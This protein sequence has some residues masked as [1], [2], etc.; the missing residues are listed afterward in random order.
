[1]KALI[2]FALSWAALIGPAR[3]LDVPPLQNRRVNDYAHLLSP[4]EQEALERKLVDYEAATKRQ[5]ALLTVP[6][7]E[8]DAIE[9]FGVRAA[10]RW[11]L[12]SE[13]A[14]DGLLFIVAAKDRRMRVEV[15]YG[16]E[17]TVTDAFSARLIRELAEPAFKA[18]K[19]AQGID[20][21]FDA[22]MTQANDGAP[23]PAADKRVAQRRK[24][25]AGKL[26]PI[27]FPLV[28]FAI[29]TLISR[30]GGGR[31]RR[32]RGGMFLGGP[33]IGGGFGGGGGWGGGG[34]DD[35]GFRGGGGGFGGGGASGSW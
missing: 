29:I 20:A 17:G 33:F 32:R 1:V 6:S 27:I 34:G 14:D 16:L 25:T 19:Y 13:K 5:F 15:G 12:G 35:G 28:L 21:T 31:G 3:A 30:G 24:K 8:G 9:D 2:I 11:K 26:S 18:E 7:L 22:L 4:A 10:T 23:P